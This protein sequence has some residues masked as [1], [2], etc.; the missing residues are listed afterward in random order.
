[1]SKENVKQQIELVLNQMMS[2]RQKGELRY[3]P[4]TKPIGYSPTWPSFNFEEV[5]SDWNEGDTGYVAANMLGPCERD[6]IISVT[7]ESDIFFNG[8]KPEEY[9]SDRIADAFKVHGIHSFRVKFREGDNILIVRQKAASD[10]FKFE[11][12]IGVEESPIMWPVDYLY[13]TRPVIIWGSMAGLEG[14][15]YSRI[16]KKG[17]ML[18]LFDMKAIEW[19]GP[20]AP[21]DVDNIS[22]NFNDMTSYDSACAFTYA[23]GDFVL[24]HNSTIMIYL[25]GEIIYNQKNGVFKYSFEEEKLIAVEAK[26]EKEGFGFEVVKAQCRIKQYTSIRNDLS[27]IWIDGVRNAGKDIRLDNPQPFNCTDG[28]RN[29]YKYYRENTYLRP[30]LNTCFFGQWFYAIMVG[31]YGLL[32]MAEKLGKHECVEYFKESLRSLCHLFPYAQFDKELF[33]APS[34]LYS[35]TKRTDLDSIGTIGMNVWEYIRLTGDEKGEEMLEVLVKSLDN[36]PRTEDGTFYRIKTF[37]AD[38]FFMSIPFLVRLGG[39]YVAE[40]AHHIRGFYEKLYMPEKKIFSHIYFVEEGKPNRIPWGRGNGWVLLA[41]S[42]FLLHA[43][44]NHPDRE[45]ILNKYRELTEGILSYQGE[46]GMWH[47]VIDDPE[48]YEESSGT[49]MFITAMARG[50]RNGWIDKSVAPKLIKAWDRLAEICIDDDGNALGICVGSGCHMEREY[51]K[52]LS[53]CVNDDHGIGIFLLA[54]SEIIDLC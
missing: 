51:Y 53:A 12:Y 27:W 18:P 25:D 19:I 28:K 46:K 45:D 52:K 7:G 22:F 11:I 5:Y 49:G 41:L 4:Y 35:S 3:A 40:A 20:I 15:N 8:E 37:W 54:A 44:E 1:M 26:K 21:A 17:E 31:H 14:M 36:V 29:F 48:T 38:D 34:F 43:P 24:K 9:E 33:G 10:Y 23:K 2:K 39:D 16:Y 47:Q 42:E 13:K 50:V 32:K 30:Y 6:M